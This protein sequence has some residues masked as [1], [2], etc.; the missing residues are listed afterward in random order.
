MTDSSAPRFAVHPRTLTL[1]L[2]AVAIIAGAA[3]WYYVSRPLPGSVELVD[4]PEESTATVG[5]AGMF[6]A[7][8][9][10][11]IANPLGIAFDGETL[12]IAESDAARIRLFDMVGGNVGVIDLGSEEPTVAVYPSALALTDDG[13][14]AVVDNSRNRV[15]VVA[16]AASDDPKVLL[17][18]AGTKKK[19]MT[20]T[21]VAYSE[22]EFYVFDAAVQG[23]RVYASDGD[24]VR[25]IG[26]DL[27][28]TPAVVSGMCVADGAVYLTDSTG[29]RVLRIDA[30]TG[31]QEAVFPDGY[32]LPR[33]VRLGPAGGVIVVDTFD[34]AVY[35][36][37]TD[38]ERGDVIDADA[39]ADGP[40][41]SPRDAVWVPQVARLY[42]TD[43]GLGRVMVYNVRGTE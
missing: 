16:A 27:A 15:L 4:L 39:V 26:T 6:P 25:T 22:G 30:Q 38:G 23:I 24:R 3:V 20:P 1:L 2:L 28:P 36:A 5:F 31:L 13:R 11:P 17:T 33:S 12:F 37:S 42:V 41:D 32:P 19:P 8:D 29:G 40:M 34:R 14:L 43:A 35:F 21:A 9:A 7:A 10:D 18:I